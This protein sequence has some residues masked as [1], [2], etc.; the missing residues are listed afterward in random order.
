MISNN[1]LKEIDIKN[2]VCYYFHATINVTKINFSNILLTKSYIE[3][4]QFKT[5]CIKLQHSK[6]ITY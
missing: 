4:F 5:F 1:E 3:M 2:S 6:A